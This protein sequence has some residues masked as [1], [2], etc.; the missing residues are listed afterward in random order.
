MLILIRHLH[1]KAVQTIILSI[2]CCFVF[3]IDIQEIYIVTLCSDPLGA[4]QR[5]DNNKIG[6]TTKSALCK[7]A[8]ESPGPVFWFFFFFLPRIHKEL[9]A[10]SY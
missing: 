5:S 10:S 3:C 8:S 7:N 2:C 6:Y 1:I 4:D 9:N